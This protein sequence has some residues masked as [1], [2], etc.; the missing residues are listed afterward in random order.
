M[1]MIDSHIHLDLYNEKEQKLLLSS[2]ISYLISVS[3]DLPSSIKNMYLMKQDKRIKPAF[4]FHPEQTVLTKDEEKKLFAWMTKHVDDM[5]AVGEV[6]LPYY[7][8]QQDEC[9][10]L[11]AYIDL[12]EKFIVFAKTYHKPIIVHAVYE[13]APIVCDLLEKHNVNKAHFHWFKGSKDCMNRM[14]ENGYFISITPDVCYER[15]IQK[16]VEMYPLELMMI[17][18]DGPWR[19]EGCFSNQMTTPHMMHQSV[20]TIAKVK[21]VSVQTVYEMMYH[22]TIKFYSLS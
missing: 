14:I 22:N 9:I 11:E 21:N 2:D 8:R 7:L 17:E 15:E 3:M 13:D 16:I 6:G 4:G 1:K 5:V 10:H 18:T 20:E 19:F 12:L